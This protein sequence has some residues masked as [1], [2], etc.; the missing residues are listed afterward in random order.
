MSIQQDGI[1]HNKYLE[2]NALHRQ[3]LIDSCYENCA[4]N[5]V[6]CCVPNHQLFIDPYHH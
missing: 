2:N 1:I 5:V 4:V 3:L 6:N